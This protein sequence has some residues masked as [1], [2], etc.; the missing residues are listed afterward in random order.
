MKANYLISEEKIVGRIYLIRGK[1]VML[2][3]DLAEMYGVETRYL[4]KAVKRNLRRFPGDFMFQL[5]KDEI[6]NLMFQFGTSSPKQQWGGIRK[7]PYAFTE[8]GVAMLSS[9]L[10]SQTAIDVNIQIIRVFTRMREML[11]SHKDLLLKLETLEKAVMEQGN[12]ISKHEQEMQA[13]FTALKQLLDP[14]RPPMEKVG[15]RR[16]EE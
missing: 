5:N 11:I 10:S 12:Y 16:K 1:K 4:N 13:V 6:E 3:R 2:D 8:Q 14:E 15:Y 9:V 7:L